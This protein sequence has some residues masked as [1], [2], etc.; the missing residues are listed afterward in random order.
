MNIFI[1]M[2]MQGKTQ[3][4]IE[5]D[6]NAVA[7]HII[8]AHPSAC[9]L[10]SIINDPPPNATNSGVWYLGRSLEIMSKADLVAFAKGRQD[11]RGCAIEHQVA[12][13]YGIP[14]IE[15]SI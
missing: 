3:Q 8:S 10:N 14:V 12:V 13:E 7:D 2:P 5:Q 4:Q 6:F 9:I 11:A 15:V 1:S